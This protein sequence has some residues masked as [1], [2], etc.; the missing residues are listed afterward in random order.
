MPSILQGGKRP[1]PMPPPAAEAP[2]PM[3]SEQDAPDGQ[4]V[5]SIYEKPDGTF[6]TEGPDGTKVDH[7]DMSTALDFI[8]DGSGAEHEDPEMMEAPEGSDYD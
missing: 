5:A 4:L 1:A 6:C 8:M 2:M 7:P 3:P